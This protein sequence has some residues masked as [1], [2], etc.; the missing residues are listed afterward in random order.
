MNGKEEGKSFGSNLFQ[1]NA[2][3]C[4]YSETEK[5]KSLFWRYIC[6]FLIIGHGWVNSPDKKIINWSF[7]WHATS[8]GSVLL[9]IAAPNIQPLFCP[10]AHLQTWQLNFWNSAR[11]VQVAACSGEGKPVL[12]ALR[13]HYGAAYVNSQDQT[14][15]MLA[16]LKISSWNCSFVL[17]S[18]EADKRII[19]YDYLH[20]F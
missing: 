12:L 16:Q 5:E 19:L 6:H 10:N 9:D 20:H 11:N 4:F 14:A 7:S 17:I 15:P 13:F 3:T 8:R 18:I 1:R 2:L